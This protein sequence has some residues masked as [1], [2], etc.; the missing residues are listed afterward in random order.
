LASGLRRL[1]GGGI[2]GD[3][4][5]PFFSDDEG[6]GVGDWIVDGSPKDDSH[7]GDGTGR[8]HWHKPLH[9]VNSWDVLGV[10][11][12][13]IGLMIA[14]A[15]G[16]GGGG[17]LVPLYILVLQFDPKHAIPLSNI[18]IFGGAITNT[19]LNLSKRHPD[20]DR[21]LVDWDLILVMEP[22]TIGGALVGSFINKVL[23]DYILAVML[24]V[25]LAATANRTLR[26]GFKAYNKETKM[27]QEEAMNTGSEL[28]TVH[29]NLQE[30]DLADEGQAL[31][32]ESQKNV[33]GDPEFDDKAF[34]LKQI[35][36]E[37]RFTPLF[38]VGTLT[39]VF[40]IVL[41]VNLLK[42]GGA[43]PSPLGIKCGSYAFWGSTVFIFIW[44]LLVSW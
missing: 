1:G 10:G 43:F 38:K 41:A 16:I 28:T 6:G 36:D 20:A 4:H 35:L 32:A 21:P 7:F 18:T 26:K 13:M 37:E 22:L 30:E 44:V 40:I 27:L 17:I 9:P 25:L 3:G 39:G 23:P 29:E 14:A 34:E 2:P 8:H 5:T 11:L 42:G 12:A 31:L 24:I 19:L 15:G 33:V